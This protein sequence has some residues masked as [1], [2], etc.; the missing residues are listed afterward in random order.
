MTSNK[1]LNDAF[2]RNKLVLYFLLFVAIF[3][4]LYLGMQGELNYLFCFFI[5][6][7]LL[8]FFT[9]NMT[10]VLGTSLFLTNLLIFSKHFGDCGCNGSATTTTTTANSSIIHN[11]PRVEGFDGNG[12]AAAAETEQPAAAA[13]TTTPAAVEYDKFKDLYDGILS[14]LQKDLL[15]KVE[16]LEQI[17]QKWESHRQQQPPSSTP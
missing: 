4:I 8:V 10:I 11:H 12:A 14:T 7:V 9:R 3:N 6:A 5:L 2:L 13:P 1:K 17:M 16:G 15:P